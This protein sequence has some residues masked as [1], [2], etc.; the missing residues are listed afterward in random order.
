M[1]WHLGIQRINTAFW[2]FWGLCAV[3]TFCFGVF[4]T[5][6]DRSGIDVCLGA[7]A[8]VFATFVAHRVSRWVINGFFSA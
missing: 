1:N 7:A 8:C 3:A 4:I 2:G 6:T 5:F